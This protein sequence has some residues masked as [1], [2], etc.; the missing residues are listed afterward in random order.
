MH[1]APG[2]QQVGVVGELE[3]ERRVLLDQQH[4]DA[5]LL[6]DRAQDLEISCTTSGARPNDGSS[7]SSR[8]GRSISA[9][10]IASICC[11]PP[12]SVPACWRR[13]SFRRGK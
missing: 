4:A 10:E 13:R 9:R 6:V 11:S 12:E 1:D 2:L 8:R 5:V 3:R 7:S